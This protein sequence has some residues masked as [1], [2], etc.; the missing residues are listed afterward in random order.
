MFSLHDSRKIL[1]YARGKKWLD[2][3]L[4]TPLAASTIIAGGYEPFTHRLASDHQAFFLDFDEAA[5]FG[6]QSPSLPSIQW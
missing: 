2:F 4:A 1:T 5:L 6:S 3:A